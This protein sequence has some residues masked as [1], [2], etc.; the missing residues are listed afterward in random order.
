MTE[1]E[2]VAHKFI[3]RNYNEL[4]GGCENTMMDYSPEDEEY[5]NA[6]KQ[7]NDTDDIIETVYKWTINDLESNHFTKAAKFAGTQFMKDSIRKLL[8][9]DGFLKA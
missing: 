8:I 9:R 3:V 2:K 1:H 4:V 7:L 6:K 5:I